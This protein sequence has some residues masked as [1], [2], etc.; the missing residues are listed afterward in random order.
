MG[1]AKVER[2]YSLQIYGP[3]IAKFLREIVLSGRTLGE[4]LLEL[5]GRHE[6]LKRHFQPTS[7]TRTHGSFPVCSRLGAIKIQKRLPCGRTHTQ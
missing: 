1:G 6:R 4:S 5:T 3:K 7:A 2:E